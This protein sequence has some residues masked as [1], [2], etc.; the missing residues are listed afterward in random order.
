MLPLY[1]QERDE[2]SRTVKDA[3]PDFTVLSY[4]NFILTPSDI[5]AAK[6]VSDA[7]PFPFNN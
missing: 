3:E 2:V 7:T 6:P 4:F 1:V 5:S